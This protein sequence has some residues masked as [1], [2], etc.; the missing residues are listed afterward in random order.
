VKIEPGNDYEPGSLGAEVL[1]IRDEGNAVVP[2]YG[3][4]L[5]AKF[6]DWWV[7]AAED[8]LRVAWEATA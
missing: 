7:P 1:R 4:L 5:L 6:N 3:D 8:G 2:G